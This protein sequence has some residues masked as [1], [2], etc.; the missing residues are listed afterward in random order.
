MGQAAVGTKGEEWGNNLK[1]TVDDRYKGI[2]M[3]KV[4][5]HKRKN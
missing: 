4:K 5:A 2:L 3:T 1:N